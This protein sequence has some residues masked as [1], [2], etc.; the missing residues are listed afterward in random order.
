MRIILENKE[1]E[2]GLLQRRF[3]YDKN[4]IRKIFDL[5][6]TLSGDYA[7][8]IS[9]TLPKYIVD[10]QGANGGL[11][12]E[13]N[14]ILL[15]KYYIIRWFH[16][17]R[18]I[19]TP[20]IINQFIEIY[21]NNYP[22]IPDIKRENDKI[23]S[24]Y[25][26]DRLID[27]KN[28]FEKKTD[29]ETQ[30]NI[31]KSQATVLMNTNDVLI[32]EP[33]TFEA[34]KYYGHNDWYI[35]CE[36]CRNKFESVKTHSR[37]VIFIDKNNP[38]GKILLSID[39]N[40][41]NKKIITDT[42]DVPEISDLYR[43]FPSA[44]EIIDELIGRS[45]FLRD[46]KLYLNGELDA[47]NIRFD[48]GDV[49]ITLKPT[50]STNKELTWVVFKFDNDSDYFK[51]FNLDDDD[52]GF[53]DRIYSYYGAELYDP[54][55][56]Q[57]EFREGRINDYFN[58][59]NEKK[60]QEIIKF[61]SPEY[62]E[63]YV[64]GDVY[65]E[66]FDMLNESFPRECDEIIDEYATAYNSAIVDGNKEYI[67]ESFGD[68]FFNYGIYKKTLF[69]EYFAGVGNLIELYEKIDKEGIKSPY[70]LL[71]TIAEDSN[72]PRSLWDNYYEVETFKFFDKEGFNRNV[73]RNL[74]SI[75]E[76]LEESSNNDEINFIKKI[77][78]DILSKYKMNK[79]HLFPYDD[80]KSFQIIDILK[81]EQKIKLNITKDRSREIIK[82]T[83]PEFFQLINTY[84]LFK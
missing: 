8:F 11:T 71:S 55:N 2:V 49:S 76:K 38:E 35:S 40:K 9:R 13:Q 24:Y 28:V 66:I 62:F 72:P 83:I 68:L 34:A 39:K 12:K 29:K 15:E 43:I 23:N 6:P 82:V 19:I 3:P 14:D 44:Y 5:D 60:F 53:I 51:L 54:Y 17:N 65:P 80:E 33:E 47:K 36:H 32:V 18:K 37:I 21:G 42:L 79:A 46:L 25:S 56:A 1:R 4:L 59:E 74:D 57:D 64:I 63:D 50:K 70:E 22:D 20:Q 41:K 78:T 52:Q 69:H 77:H 84:P 73:E 31:A 7:E 48:E 30:K 81:S 45:N 10:Y 27:L 67:E 26:P 61:L 75:L 58:L 16:Q